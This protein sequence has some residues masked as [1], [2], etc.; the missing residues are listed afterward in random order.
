MRVEGVSHA[1]L[2]LRKAEVAERQAGAAESLLKDRY[3]CPV[4]VESQ[5]AETLSPGSG[6]TLWAIFSGDR[7]KADVENPVRLGADSLGE[8]GK[9]AEKVGQEAAGGLIE[10]I[11]SGAPVDHHLADQI[12]PFM[13]L[14]SRSQ[15]RTS[16]ITNHCKTNIYVIEKFFGKTFEVNERERIISTVG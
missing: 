4:G 9:R 8:R 5:Y 13:A 10:E 7:E 2:H 6:I 16:R 11:E 12:L 14:T 15:I 3:G 1:S